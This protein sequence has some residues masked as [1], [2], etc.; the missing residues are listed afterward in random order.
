MVSMSKL[1][2]CVFCRMRA[3][4]SS[5]PGGV[6]SF[7]QASGSVSNGRSAKG[8]PDA[9]IL[10]LRPILGIVQYFTVALPCMLERNGQVT[11]VGNQKCWL[12]LVQEQFSKN[13]LPF[14]QVISVKSQA[15]DGFDVMI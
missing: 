10:K 4:S 5:R 1:A 8:V 15:K 13:D 7:T 6:S 14:V 3:S 9:V 12:C 11:V 2:P